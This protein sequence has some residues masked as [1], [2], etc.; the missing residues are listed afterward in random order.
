MVYGHIYKIENLV[1]GKIYIG[2]TK[3]PPS[4]RQYHH[5]YD[6]R[7]KRHGNV[8]LQNAF[9]KY[10]ESN[11]K[12]TV[13]NYA[14]SQKILDQ[15]EKDYIKYYDCLN[16][17]KGYN[18]REGGNGGKLALETRLKIKKSRPDISG[19]KN[20]FYGKKHSEESR[21]KISKNHAD[22]SGENHPLY[23]KLGKLNP[24]YGK[25]RTLEDRK[26]KSQARRGKGLFG[27]TTNLD[28]RVNPEKRCW[29]VGVKVNTHRKML[30]YFNDPL[31]CNIVYDLVWNEIYN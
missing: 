26:K 20:P 25:E 27:F 7:N 21:K 29:F 19:D 22:F 12:F 4:D 30:G 2:Q 13:L 28:K 16:Q 10:G 14:T 18:L 5:F 17:K 3:R 24:N 31:S 1:N 6:L 11:F 8:H 9:D 23:G 15:L